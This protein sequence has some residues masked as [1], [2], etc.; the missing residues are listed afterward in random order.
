M[1]GKV[2]PYLARID[3]YPIKSLDGVA[4]EAATVLPSGSLQYDR[5]WALFDQ[6]GKF[7][8]GKRYASIHRVRSR[9]SQDF[10]HITLRLENTG[11]AQTFHLK[12]DVT[13][14][15]N[16]FSAYFQQPV[17][18]QQNTDMGFPD[19]TDSP[20]PTVI[21]TATLQTVADWYGLSLEAMRCRFRTNLE[22]DGV[23]AFWEDRLF[24]AAG[25]PL[26]FQIGDVVLQGINPC[27][28]C[29]VPTR[30]ALTGEVTPAF[31]KKFIQQR[32]ATLPA[33]VARSR[34]NHFYRLA[35]NTRIAPQT[36]GSSVQVGDRVSFSP[37]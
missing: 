26:E 3:L 9:F 2:S 23:P 1:N 11:K 34:F 19:D 17:T 14:L 37:D 4:V 10:G 6:T 20:G 22:I 12:H 32:A 35:V 29:V 33:E 25:T 15:E 8:N 30:D 16:W 24:S 18:L 21:S 31:Q 13:V 27:Q 5:A 7:V 28:R 36:V